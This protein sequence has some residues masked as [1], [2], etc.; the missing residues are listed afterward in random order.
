MAGESHDFAQ[1][2]GSTPKSEWG[3]L[4]QHN[5]KQKTQIKNAE[6]W[7]LYTSNPL[8]A[9]RG[10]R[11]EKGEWI[12]S[13]IFLAH[14]SFYSVS[15]QHSFCFVFYVVSSY[16]FHIWLVFRRGY[17]YQVWWHCHMLT[18]TCCAFSYPIRWLFCVQHLF[19]SFA[20]VLVFSGAVCDHKNFISIRRG[21][22]TV[23][24][25]VL[26]SLGRKDGLMW[27]QHEHTRRQHTECPYWCFILERYHVV[28]TRTVITDYWNKKKKKG[29]INQGTRQNMIM[30]TIMLCGLHIKPPFLPND[31]STPSDRPD[32]SS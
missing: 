19:D 6:S 10:E 31:S 21:I 23:T 7:L 16:Y 13:A 27:R 3:V 11:D 15:F 17:R 24:G 28:R 22:G 20:R 5:Y 18:S 25:C 2:P 1:V 12:T 30:S 4:A 26:L 8:I 14:P 32:C 29:K 9:V